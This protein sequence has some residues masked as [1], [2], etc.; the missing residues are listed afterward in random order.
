MR[1][2]LL[3][4]RLQLL[5]VSSICTKYSIRCI[6]E[7]EDEYCFGALASLNS[8]I[9]DILLFWSI[10]TNLGRIWKR[11]MR[12]GRFVINNTG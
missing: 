8:A 6:M 3:Q 4:L 9:Q 10:Y 5:Q 7:V 1:L 11:Q 12:M 2:V